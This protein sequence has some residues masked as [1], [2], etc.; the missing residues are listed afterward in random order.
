MSNDW[1]APVDLRFAQE[2]ARRLALE[3][4]LELAEPFA[5]NNVSFVAPTTDGRVLKVAWE[6]GEEE[7]LHEPDAL[8]LWDGH[9]AVR[10][11]R[12]SGHAVLEERA[13]PGDDLSVENEDDATAIAVNLAH[14]LWR[15]AQ[16]PFRSVEPYVD[17]WLG[18]GEREGNE[19][20][21]LARELLAEVGVHPEWLVHG[22]FHH[23]NILRHG[24]IYVA[25]D[26]KPYLADREYD[27][28]SI[29]WNPLDNSMDDHDQTERR[30]AAF[31][32][33]G[34][35]DFKI[36]AWSVIRGSYMR[37]QDHFVRALRALIA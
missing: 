3:W 10:A 19:L 5:M 16:E 1:T 4:N 23:H 35:D 34:L 13:V 33:S 14:L 36:R 2:L 28:P 27:I 22:D 32:E 15:P 7:S 24:D 18:Y 31:V 20:I 29:L 8:E 17:I 25:I 26:P 12:R 30:I 37:P 11:Y 6:G 21:G 9:G